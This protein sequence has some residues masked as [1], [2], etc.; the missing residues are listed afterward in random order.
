MST[1]IIEIG[2][3]SDVNIYFYQDTSTSWIGFFIIIF[4][5]AVQIVNNNVV[6]LKY[7]N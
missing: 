1:S 7:G 3:Q 5:D 2:K 4:H 6:E